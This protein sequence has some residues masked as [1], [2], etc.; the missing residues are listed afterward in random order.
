VRKAIEVRRAHH[1]LLSGV[2]EWDD[3]RCRD[4]VVAFK[5]VLADHPTV[6]CVANMGDGPTPTVRGTL[7][8]ASSE[9]VDGMV[10]PDTTAWFA[11]DG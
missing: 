9:L 7:L 5:R 10:P 4:G 3:V 11:Q 6:V 1:A 8:C 2:L